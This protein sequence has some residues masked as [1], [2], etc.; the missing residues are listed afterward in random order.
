MVW[1]KQI[2]MFGRSKIAFITYINQDAT[3]VKVSHP[4]E[5]MMH[6]LMFYSPEWYTPAPERL[7]RM[8]LMALP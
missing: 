1:I 4:S 3:G 7:S 5:R 2:L 8:L 6:V